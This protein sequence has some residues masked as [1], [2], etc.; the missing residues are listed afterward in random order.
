MLLAL[1]VLKFDT[2]DG[3]DKGLELAQ[4]LHKQHLL[5]LLDAATLPWPKG[6]KDLGPL[7]GVAVAAL[8]EQFADHGIGKKFPEQVRSKVTEGSSTLFLLLGLDLAQTDRVI[9]AFKKAPKF[10]VIASNLSPEQEEMLRA[11]FAH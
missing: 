5:E 10:E 6:N 8:T 9:E 1:V 4:R 7:V 3:A 2:A 11:A